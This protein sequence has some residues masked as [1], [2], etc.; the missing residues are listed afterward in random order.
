MFNKLTLLKQVGA[1]SPQEQERQAHV[2]QRIA[3]E[4]VHKPSFLHHPLVGVDR[5]IG[6]RLVSSSELQGRQ[7]SVYVSQLRRK[8]LHDFQAWPGPYNIRHVLRSP[9]S[10]VLITCTYA[11]SM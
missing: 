2:S 8:R 4:T 6:T 5:E 3:R 1:D 9:R 7:A 11:A 10:G